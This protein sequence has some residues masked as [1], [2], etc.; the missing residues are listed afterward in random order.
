MMKDI[1]GYEGK[2]KINESGIV[3]NKNGHVMR[4]AVSNSGYL[5]TALIDPVT[6]ERKNKSIH[7]LVAETFIPNPDNLPVVMWFSFV[8]VSMSKA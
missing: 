4:T 2:Y 6:G 5:R 1:P 3:I 8:V 7:R